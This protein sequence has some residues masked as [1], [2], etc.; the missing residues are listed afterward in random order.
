LDWPL[1]PVEV[2]S[3]NPSSPIALSPTDGFI[4]E[5]QRPN[6]KYE[7]QREDKQSIGVCY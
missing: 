1:V 3:H 7:W 2:A 6:M 4:N 5:S